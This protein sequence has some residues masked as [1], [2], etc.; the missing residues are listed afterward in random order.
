M[1]RSPATALLAV[2]LVVC[3]SS[4][5]VGATL[6]TQVVPFDTALAWRT[7]VSAGVLAVIALLRG[8]RVSLADARR[9]LPLGLLVQVVYLG[10]VFAAAEAGVP[11]GTVALIAALQPLLVA[12]LA[13][14]VTGTSPTPRQLAG[15]LLGAAGVGLVVA[16]DLGT[17]AAPAAAF[18]LPVLAVA[19]LAAGTLLEG[20][21]RPTTPLVS[22]LAL[23]SGVAAVVFAAV[24]AGR[25]HLAPP[26]TAHFWW[27]VAWLV[28]LAALGGY[29]SYLL[30]VRRSGPTFASALLYLTPP[31]T[32]LWAWAM[33]GQVP[34][35]LAAPGA[36]VCAAGIGLFAGRRRRAVVRSRPAVP[37]PRAAVPSH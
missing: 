7:I 34:G 28:G 1:R 23:Q 19:G 2:L 16:G 31:T 35:P 12:G 3:W 15:L 11:T 13:G 10:G 33:F 9:Q 27:A 18:L 5:F 8:E 32:A 4:G 21:W 37:S 17:G 29:G 20:R 26:P 24:A 6:S 14:R 22:S 25:G 36:V 30:T